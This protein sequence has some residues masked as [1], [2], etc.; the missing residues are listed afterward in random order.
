MIEKR[1]IP[2]MLV[3]W[4]VILVLVVLTVYPVFYALMGSLKTN[5]ELQLGRNLL[6][7]IPQWENYKRA[8]IDAHFLRYSLNS[9]IA[10][11]GTMLIAMLATSMAG[12]VLG[13][14]DFAGKR[15]I[16]I[17]YGAM[18]FVSIGAVALFPIMRMLDVIH[19]SN[20]MF[21]LILVLTG[22]QIVNIFLVRSFVQS[23]PRELDEAACIDG[24][25]IFRTYWRII[26]PLIKP[27][28]AVVGLFTFRN[29]WNDYITTLIMTM[30][31]KGL[32]TLTVAVVQLKYS[33]M[34][35]VE[36]HVMLAGASL[37]ILPVLIL[38]FFTSKQFISGMMA[39][40]VKG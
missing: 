26:L 18:M 20:T 1:N 11:V 32:T 9:V 33:N 5:Q 14:F 12:Y 17:S 8:F 29:T 13:R 24:C 40:A 39:G 25:S 27:I 22:S 2:L 21:S 16:N 30:S 37:A 6:P 34:A 31:N 10:S 19:L 7:R 23:V 36:W 3:S 28:L 4:L 38:Y 15:L 35:A